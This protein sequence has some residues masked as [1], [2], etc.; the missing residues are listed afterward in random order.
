MSLRLR[1]GLMLLL[2]FLLLFFF[3]CGIHHWKCVSP[4]V[5][6]SLQSGRFWATLIASSR[7]SL[8][9]LRCCSLILLL[10]EAL[11]S[12]SLQLIGLDCW[13]WG[14]QLTMMPTW[15]WTVSR[16]CKLSARVKSG[17]PSNHSKCFN[18]AEWNSNSHYEVEIEKRWLDVDR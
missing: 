10:L 16:V 1:L 13:P 11:N 9:N 8:L 5:N 14:D 18:V 6:I 4:N 2:M 17:Q 15:R 3:L 12:D 7:E